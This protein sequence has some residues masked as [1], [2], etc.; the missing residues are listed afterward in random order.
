MALPEMP[1]IIIFN[2]LNALLMISDFV[3]FL[4]DAFDAKPSGAG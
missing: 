2:F 4:N 1:F 3:G